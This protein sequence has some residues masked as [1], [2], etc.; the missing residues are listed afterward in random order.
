MGG[1]GGQETRG[2]LIRGRRGK[3]GKWESN[4][5]I[6]K[7][8]LWLVRWTRQREFE[9]GDPQNQELNK[10]MNSFQGKTHSKTL[11]PK[12][13]TSTK[14]LQ[15]LY[16]NTFTEIAFKIFDLRTRRKD[17]RD[18]EKFTAFTEQFTALTSTHYS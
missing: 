15:C 2:I 9:F 14:R 18:L 12:S 5:L 10:I 1:G 7:L 8:T 13:K 17:S 3:V 16:Y 4:S 6:H 11:V